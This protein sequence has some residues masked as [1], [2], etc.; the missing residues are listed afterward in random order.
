MLMVIYDV[1]ILL[2]L[3]TLHRLESE[4]QRGVLTCVLHY[5]I[6]LRADCLWI[7]VSRNSLVLSRSSVYMRWITEWSLF[8]ETQCQVQ[9][10]DADPPFHCALT[11]IPWV[12]GGLSRVKHSMQKGGKGGILEGGIPFLP[13]C[14]WVRTSVIHRTAQTGQAVRLASWQE[15]GKARGLWEGP[16]LPG[17]SSHDSW[18]WFAS[19][20]FLP[21]CCHQETPTVWPNLT[22]S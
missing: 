13:A 12:Q 11:D 20:R 7:A 17:G 18:P 1:S 2:P 4:A 19:C 5:P 10:R 15:V 21:T 16:A 8:R 22:F 3:P 6:N 9:S 14:D